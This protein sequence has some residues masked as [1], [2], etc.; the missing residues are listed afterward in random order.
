[1]SCCERR[2][3]S[4]N[5]FALAFDSAFVPAFDPALFNSAFDSALDSASDSTLSESESL[6]FAVR[7]MYLFWGRIEL[8]GALGTFL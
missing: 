2:R 7:W 1:M 3:R 8:F 5:L 4:H 6:S